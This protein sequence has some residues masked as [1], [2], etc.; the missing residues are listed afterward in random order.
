M[1][2]LTQFA[3]Q[4]YH[5]ASVSDIAREAGISKGLIYNYY[6]SKEAL[7]KGLVMR[8][9]KDG[10]QFQQVM[11]G[12]NPD[13]AIR[14]LFHLLKKYL[15]SNK[16]LYRLTISLSMQEEL[17]KFDFLKKIMGEKVQGF[18]QA[19]ENLLAQK[20]FQNPKQEAMLLRALF[21]G[22]CLQYVL[23]GNSYPLSELVDYLIEKYCI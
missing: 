9:V 5:S 1:S 23:M 10:D 16:E 18:L 21:D 4:G 2:A 14:N 13:E 6:D 11:L 22:I 20:G 7:L 19:F 12:N 3:K 8:L 15:V 17:G